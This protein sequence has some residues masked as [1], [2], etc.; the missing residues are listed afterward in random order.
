M[1]ECRAAV[2]RHHVLPFGAE[3]QSGG[4]VRLRFFAP[5]AKAV[6]LEMEGH[7]PAAM[8]ADGHGWHELQVRDAGAGARY[9]YRL[10]DGTAVP[11]PASRFQP[12]DV[13]GPSEVIDPAAFRWQV[14]AWHG[15]PWPEVVLYELHVGTFTPE[16]TLQAAAGLPAYAD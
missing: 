2:E 8:H 12:E 16:G 11:D 3:L 14:A 10:P 15:R 4:G 9:R 13:A 1:N 7:A 5:A 6:Q